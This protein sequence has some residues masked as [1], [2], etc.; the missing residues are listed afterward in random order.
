MKAA[1][2]AAGDRLALLEQGRH[3]IAEARSLEGYSDLH[4]E[5]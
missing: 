2:A 1:L 5:H 3:R 4:E